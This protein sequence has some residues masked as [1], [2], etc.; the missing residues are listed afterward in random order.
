MTGGSEFGIVLSHPQRD[1]I[2]EWIPDASGTIDGPGGLES[3]AASST[4]TQVDAF[5]DSTATAY[6]DDQTAEPSPREDP[7]EMAPN[8]DGLDP[9]IVFHLVKHWKKTA[10]SKFDSG[11]YTAAEVYIGKIMQS[12]EA[13]HGAR[14]EGRDEIIGMLVLCLSRQGKWEETHAVLREKFVRREE[15]MEEIAT[16]CREQGRWDEAEYIFLDLWNHPTEPRDIQSRSQRNMRLKQ[17]IAEV[18]LGKRDYQKAEKWC[19]MA[20]R[21]I[22]ENV[23]MKHP[24]FFEATYSLAEIHKARGDTVEME[25]YRSLLPPEFCGTYNLFT[26]RNNIKGIAKALNANK[27]R[28]C[29]V[30]RRK[31]PLPK[32]GEDS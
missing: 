27:S 19:H 28:N 11:D 25:T 21:E 18:Y 22:K 3:Y 7:M 1:R 4:S 8:P 16:D 2:T 31:L 14:F 32:S 23:G 6:L 12:S 15:I 24:L 30:C 13:I 9:D 29:A 20:I 10:R 26:L 5:T 17:A